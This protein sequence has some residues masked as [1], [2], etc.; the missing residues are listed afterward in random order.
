MPVMF[1]T[2]TTGGNGMSQLLSDVGSTLTEIIGWFGQMVSALVTADGA[3]NPLFPLLA[4][5]IGMSI[6][7]ACIKVVRSLIWGA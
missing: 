1:L 6:A 4:L 5:G 7:F 3:L 2:A